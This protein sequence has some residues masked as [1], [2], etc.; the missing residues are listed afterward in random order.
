MLQVSEAYRK[1]MHAPMR[2]R[3]FTRISVGQFALGASENAV[4]TSSDIASYADVWVINSDAP[5]EISC[6]TWTGNG[7][8]GD[9]VQR[10]LPVQGVQG[11]ISSQLSDEDGVFQVPPYIEVEF[12]REYSMIGLTFT[13]DKVTNVAPAE[14]VV[15]SYRDDVLLN[16]QTVENPLAEAKPELFLQDVDKIVLRFTKTVQPYQEVRLS[17]LLF[18]IGYEYT[19]KDVQTLTITEFSSPLSLNLPTVKLAFTLKNLGDMF[20]PAKSDSR[21][22]FLS[23]EHEIRVENGIETPEGAEFV[24]SGIWY[25]RSWDTRGINADFTAG[26]I[27]D[28]LVEVDFEKEV[29]DAEGTLGSKLDAIISDSGIPAD[30]FSIP[31]DAWEIPNNLPLPVLNHA[32]CIQLIANAGGY[33]M[34]TDREGRLTLFRTSAEDDFVFNASSASTSYSDIANITNGSDVAYATWESEFF[35]GDGSQRI[36]PDSGYL[37]NG[38]VSSLV[39]EEAGDAVSIYAQTASRLSTG[40]YSVSLDFGGAIPGRLEFFQN[41]GDVDDPVWESRGAFTPTANREIFPVIMRD[42]VQW[43]VDFLAPSSYPRRYHISNI[44]SSYI[45]GFRLSREQVFHPIYSEKPPRIARISAQYRT[46]APSSEITELYRGEVSGDGVVRCGHLAATNQS[47]SIDYQGATATVEPYVHVSY[48][49]VQG[50]PAG[51]KARIT[52]RGNLLDTTTYSREDVLFDTGDTLPLDNPLYSPA[53]IDMVM[54]W[55]KKYALHQVEQVIDARGFPEME[56]GDYIYLE[57]G[58]SGIITDRRLD[59]N[60]ATRDTFTVRRGEYNAVAGS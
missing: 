15:E 36:L 44:R 18:G 37:D 4:I 7:L 13:F 6:A 11:F 52:V 29:W 47:V 55:T 19:N 54:A 46:V 1:A 50:L 39:A 56:I 34:K 22:S 42:V 25:L 24:A 53:N 16:T 21:T 28:R 48:V 31:A 30:R 8:R 59:G 57:D 35:R 43:R 49:T 5:V 51:E 33:Q 3:G 40:V 26:T 2:G 17:K 58:E 27:L 38:W 60:G 23:Q 9:G 45:T 20:N 10:I 14:L 32:K 12:P 41:T